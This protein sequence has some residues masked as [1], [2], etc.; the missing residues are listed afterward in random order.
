M[1]VI[2]KNLNSDAIADHHTPRPRG[3]SHPSQEGISQRFF[4]LVRVSRRED[5]DVISVTLRPSPFQETL[6][7]PKVIMLH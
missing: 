1:F 4:G 7:E 5:S 3:A 6:P 2:R